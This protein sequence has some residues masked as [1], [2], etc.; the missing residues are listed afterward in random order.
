MDPTWSLLNRNAGYA[1][2]SASEIKFGNCNLVMKYTLTFGLGLSHVP[3]RESRLV[4]VDFGLVKTSSPP[5]PSATSGS[6]SINVDS[7]GS[8]SRRLA[9]MAYNSANGFR[10]HLFRSRHVLIMS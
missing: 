7:S 4:G 10:S 3:V 2:K 5:P 1:L 9:K 6:M 8:A